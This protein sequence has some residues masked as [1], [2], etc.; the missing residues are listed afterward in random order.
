MDEFLSLMKVEM[1]QSDGHDEMSRVFN[2]FDKNDDGYLSGNEIRSAFD[3]LGESNFTDDEI[4]EMIKQ[5]D[6]NKDGL[7]DLKEFIAIISY[8]SK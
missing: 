2:F 6:K 7:I 1:Q 5:A 8:N 4:N 3:Y